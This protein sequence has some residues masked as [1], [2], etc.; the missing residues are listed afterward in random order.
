VE[1]RTRVLVVEDDPDSAEAL[2]LVLERAGYEAS[3]AA[4]ASEAIK[5]LRSDRRPHVMVLDLTLADIGGDALLAAFTKTEPL[6]PTIVISAATERALTEAARRLQ[7]RSALR[8]P[9]SA[10]ALVRAVAEAA[11][12]SMHC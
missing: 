10:D 7:A 5:L 11:A 8:K 1:T 2:V 12:L 9:F 6:P 4:R 3:S